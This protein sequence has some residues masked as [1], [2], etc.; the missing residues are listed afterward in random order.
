[1]LLP[2]AGPIAD[3]DARLAG[4]LTPDV[5]AAV[6]AEVPDDWLDAGDPAAQRARYVEYLRRRLESP[7]PFI[8]EAERARR[9]A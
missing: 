9:A 6:V 4:R 2:Y 8:D 3:A 7:R 5:I 1:M